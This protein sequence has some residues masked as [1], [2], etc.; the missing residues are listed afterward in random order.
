MIH[1]FVGEIFITHAGIEYMYLLIHV[2]FFMTYYL[3]F[4]R[5]KKKIIEICLISFTT[6]LEMLKY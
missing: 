5:E 6:A 4:Q 1:E 3:H 2:Y